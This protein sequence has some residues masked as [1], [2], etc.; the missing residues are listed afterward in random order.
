MGE[1]RG[2]VTRQT[3]A[4]KCLPVVSPQAGFIVGGRMQEGVG[5]RL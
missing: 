1:L 5:L 3:L 4:M 2:L